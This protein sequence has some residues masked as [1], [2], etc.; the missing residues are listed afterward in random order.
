MAGQSERVGGSLE[1]ARFEHCCCCCHCCSNC[2]CYHCC[3]CCYHGSMVRTGSGTMQMQAQLLIVIG[4]VRIVVFVATWTPA[5][6]TGC[7][8]VECNS[9]EAAVAQLTQLTPHG[10]W[11]QRGGGGGQRGEGAQK[12]P[13]WTPQDDAACSM[14]AT[15]TRLQCA[16]WER[17]WDHFFRMKIQGILLFGK[18][19]N[20]NVLN[21]IK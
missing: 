12:G 16:S 9:L 10:W 15:N 3:H 11:A 17:S 21:K 14:F 7:Y 8:P 4:I 6:G 5:G 2:R 20:Y 1:K 13:S 18:S 19:S